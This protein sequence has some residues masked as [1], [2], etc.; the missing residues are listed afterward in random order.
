MSKI[1]VA[2]LVTNQEITSFF[3]V[4]EL[5]IVRKS[6]KNTDY[7]CLKVQDKTGV[8]ECRMWDLPADTDVN[9]MKPGEIVKIRAQVGEWKDE[10]QLSVLQIRLVN[11]YEEELDMDDFF[12]R[13]EVH[14]EIIFED[15]VDLLNAHMARDTPLYTLIFKVIE[16]NKAKLLKAPA[17]KTIHHNYIGGLL[18]HIFSL[19]RTAMGICDRYEL[20]LDLVL[21][22]CVLHD[23]GKI[24][25]LTYPVLGYS[26]EGNLI[27]HI[28]IGMQI[29]SYAMNE[30]PGFPDITRT[31][32]LHM[33]ASHHG[34]HE[35]GSPRVPLTKEAIAFH[36]IDMVDSRMAIVD[37]LLKKGVNPEGLTE[38]SREFG[39]QLYADKKETISE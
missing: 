27:G 4:A 7:L 19:C 16:Q 39:G 1:L 13:C 24:R 35:W 30:I 10:K 11:I 12:E 17:A 37:R 6:K 3:L 8:V 9:A 18:E 2:D 34:T 38:W 22:A 15:L 25:E 23:I 36:L 26:V 14:P 20:D 33:I 31:K 29:A 21:A 32:V 28:S 5:P